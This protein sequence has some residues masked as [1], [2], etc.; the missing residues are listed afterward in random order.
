M[1]ELTAFDGRVVAW[2]VQNTSPQYRALWSYRSPT[3][4]GRL[5]G[6]LADDETFVLIKDPGLTC[7]HL[8]RCSSR[9]L[10]I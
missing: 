8:E 3:L 5:Y 1:I 2:Q 7:R 6:D 9:L 10:K 4:Y